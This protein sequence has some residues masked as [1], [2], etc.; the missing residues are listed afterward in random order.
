MRI[1]TII[2]E[3]TGAV[4]LDLTRWL[5][6]QIDGFTNKRMVLNLSIQEERI[7]PFLGKVVHV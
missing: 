7:S 6:K 1:F 5:Q 3:G 4:D 2:T